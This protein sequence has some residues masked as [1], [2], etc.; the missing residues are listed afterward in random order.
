MTIARE[1]IGATCPRRPIRA[2]AWRLGEL[3]DAQRI[4]F[5]DLL[6]ASM[7]AEGYGEATTIMW[8]DDILRG[9]EAERLANGA[10][11]AELRSQAEKVQQSRSSGNYWISLF[12][13]PKSMKGAG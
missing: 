6:A 2:V 9:I 4:A 1:P 10:V 13:D 8:I 12:G 5:H 7:S 11:P 3:S